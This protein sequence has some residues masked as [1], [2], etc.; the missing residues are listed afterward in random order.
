MYLTRLRPTEHSSASIITHFGDGGGGGE[1]GEG[2]WGEATRNLMMW[3]RYSLGR[4]H[5]CRCGTY[6]QQVSTQPTVKLLDA[7]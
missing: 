3:N 7:R 4:Q 2:N 5:C 1:G 6:C